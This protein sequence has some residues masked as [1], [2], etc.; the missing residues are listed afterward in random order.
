MEGH[1]SQSKNQKEG[2][3][4]KIVEILGIKRIYEMKIVHVRS[5]AF[6][7]FMCE[8]IKD[9]DMQQMR[10]SSVDPAIFQ[11]VGMGNVEFIAHIC[12]ANPELLRSV[13]PKKRGI[14]HFAIECRQEKIYDLIYGISTKDW[15]TNLVDSS[16]NN[17]LH[18]AGLLSPSAKLN[19]I[20]GAALQM[21]RE[22]QLFVARIFAGDVSWPTSTQLPER[23]KPVDA[24]CRA[25]ASLAGLSGKAL[26][27]WSGKSCRAK[28]KKKDKVNFERCLCG[29]LGVGLE[30]HN[31]G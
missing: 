23:L 4:S 2:L 17:M 9:M 27:S 24:F 11:A 19:R 6:L 8:E 16:S 26:S 18:M 20:P 12:K 28:L 21:Q 22:L 7:K 5:L 31:Q 14:F 25:S 29:A 13:N 15:M 10:D 3:V 30:A 1:V